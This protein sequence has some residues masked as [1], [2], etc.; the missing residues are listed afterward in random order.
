MAITSE[1]LLRGGGGA[2]MHS[3][4]DHMSLSNFIDSEHGRMQEMVE[5]AFVCGQT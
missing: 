1:L 5:Y 3:A 2:R 4:A